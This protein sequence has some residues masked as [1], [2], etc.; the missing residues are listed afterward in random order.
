MD[1][2][3]TP[4]M[5]DYAYG[6]TGATANITVSLTGLTAGST[7]TL[8]VYAA[9][10]NSGQGASLTLSGATG[11]NS[12]STLSTSAASRQIS[13]GNGVAYQTFTGTVASGGT[14]TL[15]A[16][17]LGGQSFTA[18]NGFQLSLTHP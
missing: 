2:A 12:G 1:A 17:E 6:Y 4:L 18:V 8:V 7:L 11:G 5:E 3:T 15:T 13:A 14:L 9:G 16:T 10:N